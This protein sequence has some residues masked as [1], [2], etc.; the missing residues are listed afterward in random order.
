MA[1]AVSKGISVVTHCYEMN[2]TISFSYQLTSLDSAWP[3]FY[4][5][6]DS[7]SQTQFMR[8]R[9]D[10]SYRYR[11]DLR[12]DYCVCVLRTEILNIGTTDTEESGLLSILILS[13]S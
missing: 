5:R 2:K 7:F 12:S 6:V 13:I 9:I 8:M 1:F 4:I 11:T 3:I 10:K